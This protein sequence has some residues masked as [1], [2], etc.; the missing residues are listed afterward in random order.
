MFARKI[1]RVFGQV[2][3]NDIDNEIRAI[4]LLCIHYPH[5]NIVPVFDYGP[6]GSLGRPSECYIDMELCYGDLSGFLSTYPNDAPFLKQTEGEFCHSLASRVNIVSQ[7]A[8]G[9]IFIH[10]NGQVHRDLK[11]SNSTLPDAAPLNGP[12]LCA[13]NGDWKIG[14]FGTTTAGTERRLVTSLMQR[15]TRPYMAPEL[16]PEQGYPQFNQMTDIFALGCIMWELFF[17]NAAFPTLSSI[18]TYARGQMVL[19]PP[20]VPPYVNAGR[21]IAMNAVTLVM[22]CLAWQSDQRPDAAT[23]SGYCLQL[24]NSLLQQH[25]QQPLAVV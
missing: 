5:T 15:G 9:L 18:Y 11:P 16:L 2:T 1:L 7:I 19:V 14:D 10:G 17:Q 20:P 13:M 3:Q 25:V 23:V 24:T 8:C 22:W 21:D 6:L 12:V 4:A